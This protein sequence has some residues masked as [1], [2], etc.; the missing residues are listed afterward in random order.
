MVR[1]PRQPGKFLALLERLGINMVAPDEWG[2]KS[3]VERR[4]QSDKM[5]DVKAV[6]EAIEQEVLIFESR[7]V[8]RVE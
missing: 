2:D 5:D 7:E 1:V 8:A 6:L 4:L 3:Q